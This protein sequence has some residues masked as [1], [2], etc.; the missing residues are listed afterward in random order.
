[1]NLNYIL[2][3]EEEQAVRGLVATKINLIATEDALREA[4]EKHR[5]AAK[6]VSQLYW[7]HDD[8][9]ESITNIPESFVVYFEDKPYIINIDVDGNNAHEVRQITGVLSFPGID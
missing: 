4:R 8:D 1:M 2:S 5:M 3:K 7:A 9:D 6:E